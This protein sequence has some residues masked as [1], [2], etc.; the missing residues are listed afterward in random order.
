LAL[1]ADS[2]LALSW[3][4]ICFKL[5]GQD[6]AALK[7]SLAQRFAKTQFLGETK[8]LALAILAVGDG[9]RHFRL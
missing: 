8:V 5:Y 7:N 1:K 9:A 6:D 3:A 4:S 2:G